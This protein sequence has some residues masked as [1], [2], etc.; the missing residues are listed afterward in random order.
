[1]HT[2]FQILEKKT[3]QIYKHYLPSDILIIHYFV[4]NKIW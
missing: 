1:M 2:I 4:K 3:I